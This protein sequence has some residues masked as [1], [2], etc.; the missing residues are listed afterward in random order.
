MRYPDM[1]TSIRGSFVAGARGTCHVDRRFSERG[2]HASVVWSTMFPRKS[3]ATVKS[4]TIAAAYRIVRFMIRTVAG[5]REERS[6][7][8]MQRGTCSSRVRTI[9][10]VTIQAGPIQSLASR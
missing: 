2:Y 5:D 1:R 3:T 4:F 10:S 9:S 7:L 6:R 8:V